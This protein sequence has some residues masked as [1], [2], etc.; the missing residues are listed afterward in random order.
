MLALSSTQLDINDEVIKCHVFLI[1][2]LSSLVKSG[3]LREA[4]MP[5]GNYGFQ[6]S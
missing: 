2:S 3:F 1:G 4:G 5:S 6:V